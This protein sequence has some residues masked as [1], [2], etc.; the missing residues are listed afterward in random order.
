MTPKQKAIEL[1]NKFKSNVYKKA[2]A[3]SDFMYD[4]Y[5]GLDDDMAKQCALV[6]VDELLEATKRYDYTLS[7]NPIYN[8]YWL[9]VKSQIELL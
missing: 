7:S 2:F 8:Q 1:V 4:R 6:A 9:N 3:N 5:Y